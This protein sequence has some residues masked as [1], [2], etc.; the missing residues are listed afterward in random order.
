MQVALEISQ[1]L[2]KAVK[3][4]QDYSSLV[5][6]LSVFPQQELFAQLNDDNSKKAFW[7]NSYNAF[8]I[9]LLKDNPSVLLN[10]ISRKK[11]FT[12]KA[13]TIAGNVLSLDDIEHGM[14]RNS[15]IWWS[16]GYLNKPF[17]SN[18]EKQLRVDELDPRIHFALNCGAESCP[19]VRFYYPQQLDQQLNVATASFLETE[20]QY[21]SKS[22]ILNLSKLFNWYSGDFGGGRGVL[23]F[24]ADYGIIEK[25]SAPQIKYRDYS[26]Q[27]MVGTFE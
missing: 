17:V 20:A 13:I 14:I 19:A 1:Q 25:D 16:K 15:K 2:L 23:N 8:N 5:E 22:Q 9:I 24:L 11:H 4:K 10:S 3:S 26:W 27:P 7:L 6:S 18:F 12:K 21:C